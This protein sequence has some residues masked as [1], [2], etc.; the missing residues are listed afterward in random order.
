MHSYSATYRA[1]SELN[2]VSKAFG[3]RLAYRVVVR[4]GALMRNLAIGKH[5][6]RI[7]CISK[8]STLLVKMLPDQAMIARS[9]KQ[10]STGCACRSVA[11]SVWVLLPRFS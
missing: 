11:L 4:E 10:R 1:L 8:A 7:S 6:P 3:S 2:A 5:N 9:D